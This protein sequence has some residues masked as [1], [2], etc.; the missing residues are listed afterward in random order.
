M[1]RH[2]QII[3]VSDSHGKNSRLDEILSSYPQADMYI[4]CGDIETPQGEYPMFQTVLGNNDYF[5]DYPERLTLHAQGHKILVLHGHQFPYMR[6]LERM[7]AQAKE[8]GYDIVCYGH[9]HVAH[10]EEIDGV[11]LVN[12]GS[13]W[14]ARDG[15]GPS[16]AIIS[17][18]EEQVR[19]EMKFLA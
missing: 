5:Y 16:Y 4:H 8:E 12:P 9:T 11:L 10:L 18:D 13:I 6:R 19:V 1:V 17:I 7:A 3:V 2:M 15:R 14:R